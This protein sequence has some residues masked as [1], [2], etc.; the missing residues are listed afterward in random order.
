MA[1]RWPKDGPKRG[2]REAQE[3]PQRG[4][5][6]P[7]EAHFRVWLKFPLYLIDGLQDG[8]ESAPK[9]AKRA[10]REPQKAPQEGPKRAPRGPKRLSNMSPRGPCHGPKGLKD[11]PR[12]N[13]RKGLD[14]DSCRRRRRRRPLRAL[15]LDRRS[16]RP[17]VLKQGGRTGNSRQPVRVAKVAV[18]GWAGG[19]T[20]SVNH[21]FTVFASSPCCFWR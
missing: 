16:L 6:A 11:A 20:R 10:P 7:Q 19:D 1:P 15:L 21:F 5:R 8:P 14:I 17:P 13:G 3:R 4:P 12:A 2:P 18:L 9:A